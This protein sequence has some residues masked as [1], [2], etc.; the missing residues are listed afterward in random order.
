MVKDPNRSEERKPACIHAFASDLGDTLVVKCVI[1][2]VSAKGCRVVSSRVT[3]LP[4][5]IQLIPEGLEAPIRGVIAWR[6]SNMAGVCFE[7]GCD[8]EVRSRIKELH[9]S[10]IEEAGDDVLKLGQTHEPLSYAER[11]KNYQLTGR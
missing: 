8:D 9:A 11:M 6:R 10:V 7:H 2:D 1:R 3:E 5:V 4:E